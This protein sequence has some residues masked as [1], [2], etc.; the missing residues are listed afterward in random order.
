MDKSAKFWDRIA[1]RYASRPI[2]DE[3]TYQKKLEITQEYLTPD[4]EV[5]ELGCGTGSTAIIHAPFV[6]HIRAVD[7]SPNMIDIARRRADESKVRNIHFESA[8]IDELKVT[9]ESLDV[10]L[11]LSVLHLLDN[12]NDV[13]ARVFRM[14]KPGGVFV[15]STV[16]LGG[17]MWWLKAILPIGKS[18]GL[19][20][21]INFVTGHQVKQGLFDAGF[22]IDHF[23]QPEKAHSVFIVGR[24]SS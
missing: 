3:V 14:L 19:L 24:K 15:S 8:S 1:N 22:E 10:I 20:P 21:S 4:M 12:R 2:A 5:L 13:I 16:C 23:W 7:V 6:K 11:A 18:L 17:S 9:D